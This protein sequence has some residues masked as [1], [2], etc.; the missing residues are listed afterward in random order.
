MRNKV[1]YIK[2]E[3]TDIAG[4]VAAG[5]L[6]AVR[7]M[8]EKGFSNVKVVVTGLNH[9]DPPNH[10]SAGLDKLF[11]NNGAK[12]TS[13][14]KKDRGFSIPDF[15]EKNVTTGIN[16]VLLN[17]NHSFLKD[18]TVALLI[19]ADYDSLKK[20]ET[21]LFHTKTELVAVVHNE[22]TLLNEVL[23]ALK[24]ENISESADSTVVPY[25][26][27]FPEETKSIMN[28]LGSINITSGASNQHTRSVMKI[29]I[30][31]LKSKKIIVSY[32]D[33]LGFLVNNINYPLQES[34]SL[35]DWKH[36]Y[37]NR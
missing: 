28:R 30:D 9:L 27:N 35:L 20:L 32:T 6:K 16:L 8:K 7:I 37:F 23:S 34:I 2:P 33:F 21:T 17:N 14:L 10:I 18:E 4:A 29:I 3:Q 13:Q 22:S 5:F 19:W 24:A 26:D 12:L 25:Q 31:E 11:G 36:K 15:P 1:H